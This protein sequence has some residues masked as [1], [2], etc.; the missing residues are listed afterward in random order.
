MCKITMIIN[1]QEKKQTEATMKNV[2]WVL[3]VS[4]TTS[5]VM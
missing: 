5:N 3:H 4:L 2:K 1:K